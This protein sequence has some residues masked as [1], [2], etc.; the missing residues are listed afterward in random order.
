VMAAGR[1][2]VVAYRRAD[3]YWMTPD[4]AEHQREESQWRLSTT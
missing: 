4:E 1:R 3:G 2:D